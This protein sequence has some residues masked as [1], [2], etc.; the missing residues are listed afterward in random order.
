VGYLA[1]TVPVKDL[2]E[3]IPSHP[4]AKLFEDGMR[5]LGWVDGRNVEIVWRSAEGQYERH[6]ALV[7]E[8]L[9]M[10]VD[11][12]VAFGPGV[13]AAAR[14]TRTVPIVMGAIGSVSE[15]DVGSLSRPAG[16]ITGITLEVGP[17][18]DGK[19]LSLLKEVTPT[20]RRV[21]FLCQSVL[22]TPLTQETLAAARSLG[23]SVL[24]LEEPSAD[25]MVEAFAEASRR[26]ADGMLVTDWPSYHAPKVQVAMH[27]LATRHR[28]P[29]IHS[30]LS[31][32]DTGGLM[33][34]GSDILDNYRRVPYFVDRILRGAKP[35]DLPIEQP[36]Q[37]RLIVNLRAARAIGLSLPVSFMA[38]AD[39]IVE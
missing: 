10:N 31:A 38:Q 19:R 11:V 32:A 23:I 28:L 15:T 2:I 6:A 13:V 4:A 29:V 16:N 21:A 3:R 25:R 33:S 22:G 39:R 30:I 35:A 17:T 18:L 27:E 8:L 37:F 36:T 9:A 1:N 5:G 12:I 14:K 7:D 24:A 26:G 34:Y 20:T